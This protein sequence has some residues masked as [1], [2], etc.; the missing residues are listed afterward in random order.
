MAHYSMEWFQDSIVLPSLDREQELKVHQARKSL[1]EA[2]MV[3]GLARAAES[4]R[5][6]DI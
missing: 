1:E 2:L 3:D 6:T 5:D 4:T